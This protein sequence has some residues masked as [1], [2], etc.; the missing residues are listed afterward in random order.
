MQAVFTETSSNDDPL[1]VLQVGERPEPEPAPGWTVVT[2][3][4]ATLNHHDVWSLRGVGLRAEYLP[5]TLGCDLA[6]VD[7]D[8]NEVI[9]H[10]VISEGRST[11][12]FSE[13][14]QG[15]F[16]ERV[17]VPKANLMAKPAE[18][19][20]A[21]AACLPTAW[22]TAYQMLFEKAELHP[23]D[24]VLIQGAGGG[25]STA[26]ILLAQA[27][28]IRVWVTS[29]AE[30]TRAFALGLGADEAYESGARLPDRVDAVMDSVGA[31]TWDHSLKC[32][33]PGGVMVVSGGTSGYDAKVDVAR[34]F[35]LQLRILG[36]SMGSVDGLRKLT[37]FCVASGVRP[38]IDRVV[39]LGQAREGFTAMVA[40]ELNGKVVLTN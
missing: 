10:A 3:K 5:M 15:T 12:L 29:R 24:T 16:S 18:L 32:L 17:A 13:R 37:S 39:P 21:E 30:R 38:P 26:L 9:V 2:L 19:T 28:G 4:A 36:S 35:A 20:F 22:L 7:P 14:H 25:L 11:S 8:G 40:G 27:A 23:G 33:R 34:I 1:S 6:G 31:A